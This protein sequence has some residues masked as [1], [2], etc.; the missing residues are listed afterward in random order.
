MDITAL[1]GPVFSIIAGIGG[2]WLTFAKLKKMH[3]DE[4]NTKISESANDHEKA[5]RSEINLVGAKLELV[6]KDVQ[7]LEDS[8]NKEI[9]YVKEAYKGEIK[10]LG[11][12]IESLRSQVQEH[13]NQLIG[14]LTKLIQEK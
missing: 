6:K 11:E 7:N 4:I 14:L 10:N 8:M 5:L 3:T 1:T 12:K 9:A 13:H 2:A